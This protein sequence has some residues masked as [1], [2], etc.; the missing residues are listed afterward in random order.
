MAEQYVDLSDLNS[1]NN[2][3][4][5]VIDSSTGGQYDVMSILNNDPEFAALPIEAKIE[6][7]Q[8]VRDLPPEKM[9]Q[10]VAEAEKLVAPKATTPEPEVPT[11]KTPD[12]RVKAAFQ[13][14]YGRDPSDAE[15]KVWRDKVE[16]GANIEMELRNT[17]EAATQGFAP[18]YGADIGGV[19]LP[20]APGYSNVSMPDA[21][22]LADYG[23]DV[24]GRTPLTYGQDINGASPVSYGGELPGV[25]LADYG[26]DINGI[27]RPV[28][29][30]ATGG[31]EAPKFG[32]D[33]GGVSLRQ[34]G[35]AVGGVSPVTYGQQIAG[36]NLP[37]YGKDIDGMTLRRYGEEIAGRNPVN[38]DEIVTK[39]LSDWQYDETPAF[40]A[41][42]QKG[43]QELQNR[44][45]SRGMLRGA[46]AASAGAELT[47]DLYAQ[48]YNNER[49][50]FLQNAANRYQALGADYNTAYKAALDEYNT[51]YGNR[52]NAYN[53]AYG[54]TNQAYNTALTNAQN[55]YGQAYGANTNAYNTAYGAADR[56]YSNAYDS[57][58][59]RYNTTYGNLQNEYNKA[60]G[61]GQT[62][63]SAALESA[64][65]NALKNYGIAGEQYNTRIANLERDY[66]TLL[67][68]YTRM[69]AAQ[70]SAA[71]NN[72]NQILDAIKIGQGATGSTA[73]IGQ[74]T[75]GGVAGAMR[76]EGQATAG[77][78]I[79]GGQATA[80]FY[81]GIGGVIPNI[82]S[83]TNSL[84]E[85]DWGGFGGNTPTQTSSY[86]TPS[87]ST[88]F[89]NMT[90]KDLY[91][92][93]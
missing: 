33:T 47:R 53:T 37:T 66:N 10:F 2:W 45:A 84:N 60:Y 59:N 50:Y 1:G 19:S 55:L 39:P 56:A 4:D 32:Q 64:N 72:Y 30:T 89:S 48:D 44:L 27:A 26:T 83:G 92:A 18:T 85:I 35:D 75:A 70:S 57:N 88:D 87:F 86:T 73:T 71:G 23:A 34:Y 91:D 21:P 24:G 36:Q 3:W 58:V 46:T 7:V 14:Y 52:A 82:I 9:T 41:K 67:N 69:F 76:D 22:K 93:N 65:T 31:Y 17:P 81:S 28:Y 42:N 90:M 20:T 54:A 51:T 8:L 40:I 74:N 12:D 77:G 25:S 6:A 49:N 68:N 79:R 29:G 11:T 13:Q 78:I 15:M 43:Q 38:Y 63:Y 5:K 16:G 80:G 62:E 61:A